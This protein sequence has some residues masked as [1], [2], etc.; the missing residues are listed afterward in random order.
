ADVGDRLQLV[1]GVDPRERGRDGHVSGSHL[2]EL[3]VQIGDAASAEHLDASI[4]ADVRQA[5]NRVLPL[6]AG[7]DF[8]D[9][10]GRP[11]RTLA[12]EVNRQR[13]HY[14]TGRAGFGDI[15][16]AVVSEGHTL[17]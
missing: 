12:T 6:A 1:V 4:E 9:T 3:A 5:G 14:V 16:R 8:R 10:R 17:G 7:G 11:D 13:N 2:V 15:E